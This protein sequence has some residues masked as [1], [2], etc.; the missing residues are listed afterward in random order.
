EAKRWLIVGAF[1]AGASEKHVARISGLSRTAVR[2]IILNYRRT[3]TPCIPKKIPNKIRQKLIV[4][5]DENGEIINTDDDDQEEQ[6][7]RTFK[8]KKKH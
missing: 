5:Y 1:Q 3:G 7:K 4:E 8:K 2:N 6:P